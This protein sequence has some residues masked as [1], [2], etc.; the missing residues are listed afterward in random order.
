MAK[1]SVSRRHNKPKTEVDELVEKLRSDLGQ[2]YGLKSERNGDKVNFKGSGVDGVLEIEDNN[3][4]INIKLG[5][6]A[7]ML[8]GKIE[9][10]LKSKLAQ[11]LDD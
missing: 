6:M 11:Y 9:S 10:S 5:M 7:S 1:I 4:A 8:S 3:V 2:K